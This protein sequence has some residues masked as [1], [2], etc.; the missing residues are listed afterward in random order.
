MSPSKTTK[1][2]QLEKHSSENVLGAPLEPC[3]IGQ[4]TGFF[5]DGYCRTNQQDTGSHVICA[6]MTKEFLAFSRS[7]G[8]D[9]ISPM[10]NY[11]FPGLKPGDSWCLCASRWREALI[12]GV[13]PPVKLAATHKNALN[14]VTL[15]ALALHTDHDS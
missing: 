8:N 13:A 4:K 11:G 5:R 9:L 6:V 10:P 12:A 7:Q 15:K 14:Y 3:C 2:N 1:E